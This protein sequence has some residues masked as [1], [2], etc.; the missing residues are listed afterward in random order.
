MLREH[1][2]VWV[3]AERPFHRAC[4]DVQAHQRRPFCRDYDLQ[5]GTGSGYSVTHPIMT[6]SATQQATD[7]EKISAAANTHDRPRLAASDTAHSVHT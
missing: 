2:G 4:L 6:P 7:P 3:G 1:K 5:C